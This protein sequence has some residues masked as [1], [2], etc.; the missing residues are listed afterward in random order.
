MN[1]ENHGFDEV[2]TI[3][4]ELSNAYGVSGFEK[5]VRLILEKYWKQE[6]VSYKVDGMGNLL[7]KLPSYSEDKPTVLIMA[8]MDE[9]GFMVSKIDEQGFIRVNA[10]GG[11]MPQVLWAKKWVIGVQDTYITAVSGMDTPHA[12]KNKES[13]KAD[14]SMLFLDTGL[15]RQALIDRGVRPGLP[16]IPSF[17]FEILNP[18]KRYIGKAFDDRVG[19]AI[20]VSLMKAINAD[21]SAFDSVNTVFAAT[22]QEEVGL[23]G[24]KTVYQSLKPD[25]V[26]NL[27][28]GVARD[29]PRL[30]ASGDE[31]KL[32]GGPSL[33]VYDR[34]MIPHQG[35]VESIYQTAKSEGI[36]VQ[37]SLEDSYGQDASCLQ[38]SHEGIPAVNI[39]VPVRY[40]HSHIGML[41][42]RDYDYAVRL[43]NSV[44]KRG[45]AD[46]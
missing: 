38:S 25:V 8:H 30:F 43:I 1:K 11:W 28:F 14:P 24:A 33:F 7:G 36:P 40:A 16:V 42:R 13:L 10:L 37:W 35:L 27:E 21:P 4:S 22:V 6:G 45:T 2:E 15:T 3:L 31:P 39:G 26:I 34:T 19:L 5:R 41:D 23:R 18:G 44:L 20:M 12:V 29:Y 46:F 9:I 17:Q 32:G